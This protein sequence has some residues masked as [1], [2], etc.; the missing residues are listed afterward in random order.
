MLIRHLAL[1]ALT[2][3]LSADTLPAIPPRPEALKFPALNYEP[4]DPRQ[5]RVAL[6][7]GPVAYVVPDRELPLVTVSILVRSGA[8]LD[9][10]GQE[11]LA[12]FT[13]GLLVRGGTA[14]RRQRP[15]TNAWLFWRLKWLRPS[16]T[17][18][19]R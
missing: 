19:A 16:V 17:T 1:L 12:A 7:A 14:P 3:A 11:G 9:P 5:Y 15:W 6:K 4:P 13:G 18:S 10:V 2:V 8:Y